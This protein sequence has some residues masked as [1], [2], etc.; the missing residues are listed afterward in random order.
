MLFESPCSRHLPAPYSDVR[1]VLVSFTAEDGFCYF[2]PPSGQHAVCCLPF[3]CVEKGYKSN[4]HKVSE[5]CSNLMIQAKS[6]C[7]TSSV[8]FPHGLRDVMEKGQG[9]RQGV[10]GRLEICILSIL[11]CCA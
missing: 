7:N 1:V 8:R 6:K 10:S 5:L 3:T 2:L 4:Q 11:F 9:K